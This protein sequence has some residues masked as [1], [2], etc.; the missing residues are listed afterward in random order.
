MMVS[1]VLTKAAHLLDKGVC[2]GANARL[3]DG[4]PCGVFDQRAS[5]L[6]MY[7]ALCR[8]LGPGLADEK[9]LQASV[10]WKLISARAWD[11][12]QAIAPQSGVLSRALH[13]LNE[14]HNGDRSAYFRAWAN[15]N[16]IVGL[17][18]WR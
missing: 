6:S 13:D 11:G 5:S 8:V 3:A 14:A 2:R 10:A 7:G 18:E 9:T 1:E 12:L 4:K 16:E 17:G 15:D